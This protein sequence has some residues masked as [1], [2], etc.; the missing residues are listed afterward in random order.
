L[1]PAF[2]IQPSALSIQVSR[3][4]LVQI[5]SVDQLSAAAPAWDD[6]WR[7]SESTLPTL[8]ARLVAQWVRQFAPRAEFHALAVEDQGQWVAALPLVRRKVA[9]LIDAGTLPLN[10]WSPSG[11]LLLDSTVRTDTVLD[12]LVAALVELP[13]GLWW[14]DEVAVDAPRWRAFI[15]AAARAAIAVHYQEQLRIGRIEIDHDW[16]AYQHRW[17]RK[18]RQQMA[19]H[20]RRLAERGEV[21]FSLL[22]QLAPEEV[23]GW[24][25]LGFEVEDRSWK[26]PAGTSVLRTPGMLDFFTRQAEELA[27]WGLLE[28]AFLECGGRPVAFSYGQSAKGVYHSLKVGYD[29][30]YAGCSPGQLLRY[31]LYRRLY[32][33]PPGPTGVTPVPRWR[34][35]E[36]ITPS[37]AHW[38][39]KPTTYSVGRLV[40]APRR[41]LARAAL[42]AYRHYWPFVRRLRGITNR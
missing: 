19:R 12:L 5:A 6:L 37:E 1:S 16:D 22:S 18:H 14:L 41:L 33:D 38:K 24:M 8:R 39:W 40:I 36:Y 11:D 35:I 15:A 4:R 7:R 23:A 10:E 27:R 2:S 21:R 26:G 42:H 32:G 30:E 3:P 29:P 20:A 34:A 9:R 25:R 13:W 28:L 17:S 31:Y